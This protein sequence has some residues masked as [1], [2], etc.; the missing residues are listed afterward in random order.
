MKWIEINHRE[1]W[2]NL[3]YFKFISVQYIESVELTLKDKDGNPHMSAPM[4]R[5]IGINDNGDQFN[6]GFFM[7]E[8]EAKLKIR[9]WVS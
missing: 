4:Y 6:L 5:I 2:Y 8:D 1:S 7:T 9:E 3:D